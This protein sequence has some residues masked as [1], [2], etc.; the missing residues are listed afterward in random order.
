M[1]RIATWVKTQQQ[2]RYYRIR[3]IVYEEMSHFLTDVEMRVAQAYEVNHRAVDAR[4]WSDEKIERLSQFIPLMVQGR[5]YAE[6]LNVNHHLITGYTVTSNSPTVGQIAWAAVHIVFGGTDY[7]ITDGNCATTDYYLW[8]QKSTA[9]G[10]PPSMSAVMQKAIA[11]AKPTLATGDC[12][13]FL[14]NS[15]VPVSVLEQNIPNVVANNA[16]DQNAL[17]A[18]SVVA[19]KIASQAVGAANIVNNSITTGQISNTAGIT[20][21]QIAGTTIAA[22]NIANNTITSSQISNTAG[23]T[24]TQIAGTTIQASNIANQTIT[25]TQIS[26]TANIAGS[27]L[28]STANIS[29]TQLSSSANISGS[30]L[31]PTAGL[32]G[33]QLTNGTIGSN[34]I[35]VGAVTGTKLSIL[36]HVIY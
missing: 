23:I 33:S 31:S 5:L 1:N 8:F 32:V 29:G 19:G 18:N 27:Q 26:N 21:T 13:I 2:K 25:S 6:D 28:S 30:Q 20:G 34:Q 14:N 10:T 17:Q 22:G 15:G 24:G 4:S 9:T 7:A 35:G 3:R 11:T 12:I 16:I 36:E